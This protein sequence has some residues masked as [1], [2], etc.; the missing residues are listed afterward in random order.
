ME[1]FIKVDNLELLPK[2]DEI[3]NVMWEQANN[4]SH[5]LDLSEF[6]SLMLS[7]DKWIDDSRW[8]NIN[9]SKEHVNFEISNKNMIVIDIADDAL[10]V[11]KRAFFKGAL[12]ICEKTKGMI[13]NDKLNWF[14]PNDFKYQV[15]VYIDTSFNEGVDKSFQEL[16]C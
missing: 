13:S 12:F 3:K 10:F 11:D 5:S 4:I 9:K 2:R 16:G 6:N 8:V 7:W 14:K 15:R 1:L